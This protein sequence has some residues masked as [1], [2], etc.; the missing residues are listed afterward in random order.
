MSS[1]SPQAFRDRVVQG[2]HRGPTAGICPGYAQ[3]NLIV[4]RREAAR[5][6]AAFAARNQQACPVLEETAVGSHISRTLAPGADILKV[7]PRYRIYRHGEFCEEVSDASVYW[8]EDMVCFLIGCSFSFEEA[9]MEAGLPVRHIEMDRNVPMYRSNIACQ[10]AGIFSGPVVVS[11]RPMLPEQAER[12]ARITSR[13][14]RVHGAPLHIGD[15]SLIGIRDI[16]APDYGDAVDIYPGEVPVFWACGV[17]PQA[18]VTEAKP[19]IALAHAPGHMFVSD[20][21]NSD[22][23]QTENREETEQ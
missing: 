19:E 18:A 23:A 20:I 17:T 3:A 8:Q 5:D 15:P 12:A 16:M 10:P 4:L 11:M 7:I 6:F 2:R 9:L 22:L 1:S 21:L 13:F 14:P